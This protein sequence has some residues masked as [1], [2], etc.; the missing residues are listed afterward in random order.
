MMKR[1]EFLDRFVFV[2]KCVGCGEILPYERTKEAFCET[3]IVRWRMAKTE[4]CS[5][6]LRVVTECT[7]APKGLRGVHS[8]RKLIFYHSKKHR[9]PQN[10]LIYY[11]KHHANARLSAFVARELAPA[12]NEELAACGFA[13]KREEVVIVNVPRGRRAKRNYGHDQSELICRALA[14]NC[15]I[16]YCGAIL[17]RR[18]GGKEQKKLTGA[19]RFANVKEAF[20]LREDVELSGKCVVLLDDVV[21]TGASMF[22]C[23]KLLKSA[24]AEKILTLCIAQD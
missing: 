15:Q 19:K 1:K 21:T 2:R 9:E 6:C 4:N 12:L 8:L 10:K 5:E 23:V 24:G 22:W 11:L 14:E 17:R 3:C 18:G 16:T 20:A 7:C 13:E